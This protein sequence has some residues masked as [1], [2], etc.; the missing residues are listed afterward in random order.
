MLKT[1]EHYPISHW[2]DVALNHALQ[3]HRVAGTS[4]RDLSK[5]YEVPKSTIQRHIKKGGKSKVGRKTV[6]KMKKKSS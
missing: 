5:K 6:L 4:I 1:Y 3:E 2:T